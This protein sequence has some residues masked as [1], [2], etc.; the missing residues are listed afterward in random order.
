LL[1]SPYLRDS[2]LHLVLLVNTFCITIASSMRPVQSIVRKKNGREVSSSETDDSQ[3]LSRTDIGIIAGASIGG[4][5]ILILIAWLLLPL[6]GKI[7][8]FIVAGALPLFTLIAIV[9]QAVVYRRQWNVMQESLTKTDAIIEKMQ[10]QFEAINKQEGHLSVQAEAA[11]SATAIAQDSLNLNQQNTITT[12]RAYVSVTERLT[13]QEGFILKIENTGNTPALDVVIWFAATQGYSP[14]KVPEND[15]RCYISIGLL[16]PRSSYEVEVE[17][18]DDLSEK[19]NETL[20]M[21]DFNFWCAGKIWYRD[22]FQSSDFDGHT[23]GFCFYQVPAKK[24]IHAWF[25]GNDAT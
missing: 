14:P 19:K 23:T 21:E 6:S 12:Q 20:G 18:R 2:V 7:V 4:L 16:A 5:T 24:P 1:L 3:K 15:P 13:Y 17:I 25:E 22:I 11:K 10:L 8:P 9:Y